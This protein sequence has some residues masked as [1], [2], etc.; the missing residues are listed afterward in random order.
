MF[1][2]FIVNKT[3][4]G[5]QVVQKEA[6]LAET[7]RNKYEILKKKKNNNNK[8]LLCSR[9][10]FMTRPNIVGKVRRFGISFL[11]PSSGLIKQA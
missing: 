8:N 3:C 5:R 9:F 10:W 7:C 1:S 6:T 2:E 4:F 11:F